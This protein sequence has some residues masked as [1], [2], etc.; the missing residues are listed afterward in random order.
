MGNAELGHYIAQL[1]LSPDVTDFVTAA[2]PDS[3]NMLTPA[4]AGRLHLD[5]D[6][7]DLT[8]KAHAAA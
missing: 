2:G 6:V 3:I 1:G 8:P 5:V 7:L 4:D